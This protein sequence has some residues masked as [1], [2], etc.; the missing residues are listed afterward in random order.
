MRE[1]K[2]YTND[3]F[4][5]A[6]KD[7]FSLA[8][9]MR[10]LGLNPSGG[11][12]YDVVNARIKYLNLSISHFT[13]QGHLKGKTHN[14]VP[15]RALANVLIEHSNYNRVRLKK[16]LIEAQMLQNSCYVCN[17]ANSW[18]G[19]EL[20]LHLDHINGVKDD[21]RIENLRLLCPNCHSQT[22]T[23]CSKNKAKKNLA[24]GILP[25]NA[26]EKKIAGKKST[27]RFKNCDDCGIPVYMKS[28]RCKACDLHRRKLSRR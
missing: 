17:I 12:G 22:D 21:N 26:E 6:V 7:S 5:K 4:K 8:E 18:Q 10:K 3:E 25:Q 28:D 16:R 24:N 15:P 1:S 19:K 23:Y 14:Y 13:G 27:H 11:G 20:V 9:V 2:K